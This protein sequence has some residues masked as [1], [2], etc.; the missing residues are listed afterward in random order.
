MSWSTKRIFGILTGAALASAVLVGCAGDA[1]LPIDTGTPVIPATG[2]VTQ[3]RGT[4]NNTV[5][6]QPTPQ[7]VQVTREDGTTVTGTL[8]S[9][10]SLTAGD[11]VAVFEADAPLVDGLTVSGVSAAPNQ[12]GSQPGTITIYMVGSSIRHETG[13]R[14]TRDG[15]LGGR[16]IC[17]DGHFQLFLDGPFAIVR[18]GNRLDIRNF[19]F[20]MWVRNGRASLPTRLQGELPVDGGSS[21]PLRLNFDLPSTFGNGYAT[22]QVIHENGLLRQTR[23]VDASGFGQFHDIVLG[24]NSMIPRVGVDSVEFDYSDTNPNTP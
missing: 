22:L 11:P 24:E 21:F 17:P 10:T 7:Q 15:R 6:A 16:I 12:D 20:D 1:T 5:A 19:V 18:G 14:I 8:P 4:S 2:G 23:Q 3:N 13:L 9:N